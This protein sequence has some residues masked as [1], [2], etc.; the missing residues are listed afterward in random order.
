MLAR[1]LPRYSSIPDYRR[2]V[3]LRYVRKNRLAGLH[4]Q[5]KIQ[6]QSPVPVFTSVIW[7]SDQPQQ[8]CHNNRPGGSVQEAYMKSQGT[9]D[10]CQ[11]RQRKNNAEEAVC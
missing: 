4:F 1:L 2:C 3:F 8:S 5:S 11:H 9:T 10:Y 6:Y 7:A